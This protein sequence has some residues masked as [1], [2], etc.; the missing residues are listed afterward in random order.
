MATTTTKTAQ[1]L[2]V[3]ICIEGGKGR[4][5]TEITTYSSSAAGV[6]ALIKQQLVAA[7]WALD[8]YEVTE[9]G[10]SPSAINN[11]LSASAYY[12]FDV[13]RSG[14]P[15]VYLNAERVEATA[16]R[17]AEAKKNK[18]W[19]ASGIVEAAAAVVAEQ[20]A[21]AAPVA[22]ALVNGSG[23]YLTRIA[24]YDG[25]LQRRHESLTAALD[26]LSDC[27]ALILS[28]DREATP[29][30]L[31]TGYPVPFTVRGGL[32]ATL[33]VVQQ[34][35]PVAPAEPTLQQLAE[36]LPAGP[37][38]VDTIGY[39]APFEHIGEA[40][41][42]LAARRSNMPGN[43]HNLLDGAGQP[44][45]VA[46]ILQVLAQHKELTEK[47]L[48]QIQAFERAAAAAVA[49]GVG[50]EPTPRAELMNNA[51]FIDAEPTAQPGGGWVSMYDA[52]RQG[53][54]AGGAQYAVV[55]ELHGNIGPAHNDRTARYLMAEPE[56]FCADCKQGLLAGVPA[57]TPL[58]TASLAAGL[59]GWQRRALIDMAG[60]STDT[61]A[62]VLLLIGQLSDEQLVLAAGFA[63]MLPALLQSELPPRQHNDEPADYT[64]TVWGTYEE[65]TGRG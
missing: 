20:P 61:P 55:C 11:A 29:A 53:I 2:E 37:F 21:E 4:N 47:R 1:I 58:A 30:Y 36:A 38:L 48:Y 62:D 52:Q 43:E 41:L 12:S 31:A 9:Q 16:E 24:Q 3:Y 44:V 64:G 25:P 56:H 19:A 57:I 23:P 33:Q 18:E 6:Q 46:L 49:P 22:E 42:C 32:R 5:K 28:E 15:R 60:S 27:G 45:P 54:D 17:K 63:P 14:L 34:P 13:R 39:P 35:V 65:R 8:A 59:E 7:G 50:G 26:Y 40:C 10:T 51:G